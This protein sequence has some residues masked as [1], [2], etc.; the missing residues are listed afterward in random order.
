MCTRVLSV[1]QQEK[2]GG[3]SGCTFRVSVLHSSVLCS[4]SVVFISY[5]FPFA[6]PPTL[7]GSSEITTMSVPLKGHM[8]LECRSD[9]ERPP[10]IQWYRDGIK[11]QVQ[12]D[13][14][15]IQRIKLNLMHY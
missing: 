14:K 4:L 8:T 13:N 15:Y 10:E 12:M 5:I 6:V 9:S 1:T 3:V 11:V 7:L 2:M